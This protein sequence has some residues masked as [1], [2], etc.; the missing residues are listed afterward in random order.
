MYCSVI[1]NRLRYFMTTSKEKITNIELM[2]KFL[3]QISVLAVLFIIMPQSHAMSLPDPY[4]ITTI[5]HVEKPQ[6][7]GQ[8]IKIKKV[9]VM[10]TIP[11]TDRKGDFITD[12]SKNPFDINP[13]ILEQKVEFDIKTGKYVV[14][15]K[16]GDEYY[17]TPTYLTFEEYLDYKSKEQEREYFK[18]LA[19]IQSRKK[20]NNTGKFN[21]MS[22]IDVQKSLVDRLF[23]GTEINVKPQ[24]GIDLTFGFF[25]YYK[26]TGVLA[27]GGRTSPWNPIDP[28]DLKPR[29]TVDGNV[30]SKLK[31]NFNYDAQS[32]FNFDQQ[33]KLKY[34]SEAGGLNEDDIIKKIE[35]GNVS[36]PLKGNLIQGAQSL[37]GVKTDLQFGHLRMTLLASQQ[38][39][40]QNNTKI[41]NG[42]SVQ[43]FELKPDDYDEN[44]HFFLSHF[45]RA[46]Y[47]E[48]LSNIPFIKSSFK[49]AQ[50]QVWISDDRPDYQIGQSNIAAI[51]DL[52]EGD[53][54]KFGNKS[55]SMFYTPTSPMPPYLV[56]KIGVVL[57]DNKTNSIYKSLI[58]SDTTSKLENVT[59]VL[60][61]K[62][63][64]NQTTDF[65]TF[66][67]RLLNPSEYTYNPQLGYIS[68]NLRLR[69]D[70]RLGVAYK[71]FYT[72]NC[73][74]I[75]TV[76]Q[77]SG[78]ALQTSERSTSP[79][80]QGERDTIKSEKVI[81]VKLLKPSNQKVSLP[82]WDLM[83]K[84]VYRLSTSSLNKEGFTFDI[85][86]KND[87]G[88]GEP[89]KYIPE[90]RSTPLLN[91]FNLDNLNRFGDPQADG[92]F[93]YVQGI[94]VNEKT[95]SIIFPVLEPFGSSLSNLLNDPVLIERY[96]YQKL[97]DTTVTTARQFGQAQNKF[98][99]KGRVKSSTSG[100]INLGPFVPRNGVKVTAGGIALVEGVDYEIDYSLGKLRVLNPAYLSQGTPINVSYEDQSAFS[101][102][103][104]SMVGIRLDYDFSKKFTMGATYLRLWERPFTQK[105]NLGDDPINNRIFGIDMSYSDKTPWV[106]NMID[107]L[108]FYSTKAESSV[109]FSAEAAYLKP[110][111]VKAINSE[112]KNQDEG[113]IVYIDDFEGSLSGLSLGGFNT[114]AWT[115]SSTPPE[116]RESE[117][118]NNYAYGAN[119]AK[120]SW[121][122]IDQS[123]NNNSSISEPIRRVDQAHPYSRLVTQTELFNRQVQTGVNQL[124]TFDL[125]F[126]PEL[127]GPY[128]FDKPNGYPGYS[129]GT[130][131]D[132]A[133]Q[134]IRLLNPKT[135]WGG[136]MRY[137]QNTDF[138]ANNYQFI[139]FWVLNPFLGPDGQPKPG[140]EEGEMVF[141]LGNVSEDVLRDNLQFYENGLPSKTVDSDL[142]QSK[143]G[144]IP[145]KIPLV[146]GFVLDEIGGQDLGFD[147]MN[148]AQERDRYKEFLN[149]YASLPNLFN[150]PA[151]DNFMFYND[152]SL[153]NQNM[154]TRMQNFSGP[155]GNTPKQQDFNNN[156]FY[157]GSKNPDTE[158]LNNNKALEQNENY[159]EY[160]I[161]IKNNNGELDT[162]SSQYYR[163]FKQVKANEK[164]YR[165]VVPLT[166]PTAQTGIQGFR[167][168]QFM[169]MYLTKFEEQKTFRM[170]EFQ[171]VR[172]QW[173][174]SPFKTC[175]DGIPVSSIDEVGI[176]ENFTRKPIGYRLVKGVKQQVLSSSLGSNLRQNEKSIVLNFCNLQPGCEV[177]I[178]KLAGVKL[179]LY[180]RLQMFTHLEPRDANTIKD[181]D[182][183][184]FIKLGK[185]LENNYYEYS[186]PLK[187]T[188]FGK[189]DEDI[190]NTWP[191][192]NKINALFSRFIDTK[193]L[194][195]A[196][197]AKMTTFQD[198]DNV[199]ALF[200]I[201][202][203]PSLGDV[204]IIEIGIRNI[205]TESRAL[206]G[207]AWFNELRTTGINEEGAVAAQAKAQAKIAD[208]G[209]INAAASYSSIGFGTLDNRLLERSR[210]ATTQFDASTSLGLGKLLPKFL[211]INLPFFAQYTTSK[212]LPQFD[213]YQEDISTAELVSVS[214]AEQHAEIRDRAAETTTIKSYNVTNIRKE[215]GKG[216]KP[217][218]IENL[219][220]SY[221]YTNTKKTDPIIREDVIVERKSQLD[222]GYAG[223]PNYIQPLKFIKPKAL[224]ILSEFNFN[225]LPTSF[226]FNTNLERYEGYKLFR[227]PTLP[228]YRFDDR[229]YKWERNYTLDWDFTKALRMNFKANVTSVV[230]ELRQ[231]GIADDPTMRD[232]VNEKDT[233]IGRGSDGF[234]VNQ[235]KADAYR[236]ANLKK[237][238]RAKIYSHNLTINYKLPISLL[239]L[240]DWVSSSAEYR[241]TYGWT[242]GPLIFIDNIAQTNGDQGNRPGNII[243]NTQ[244]RSLNGT[245]AFDKLYSK[246]N[247][248]KKI[249]NGGP[250][251]SKSKKDDDKSGD[252]SNN[253]SNSSKSKNSKDELSM[254]GGGRDRSTKGNDGDLQRSPENNSQ[255]PD[256]GLAGAINENRK[257]N[258]SDEKSGENDKDASDNKNDKTAKGKKDKTKNKE[259]DR[260]PSMVERVLIRPLLSVRNVKFNYKEE[261]GTLL[262]GFMP[263]SSLLG[264]SD[265]FTSPG[266]QFAA[267]LQPDLDRNNDK[268][269]LRTNKTWFNPSE[270]FNDQITQSARQNIN[271][272]IA[273]EPFKDFKIDVDF[274]KDHKNNHTEIFKKK[275]SDY[276]QI[277]ALDA[278]SFETT[279]STLN[280]LFDNSQDV[281]AQFKVN[282]LLVAKS[283]AGPL[284]PSHPDY[285]N[286]PKGY[287]PV[288]YNVAVPAFLSAYSGTDPNTIAKDVS[289]NI[290]AYNYLPKP[291]WQLRYDGLSKLPMFKDIF[292]SFSLK[293][294]YKSI[295]SVANFN[296]GVDYQDG[297]PFKVD[298]SRNYYSRI[299]IPALSMKEDFSPLI[300]IDLKTKSNMEIKFEYKKGRQ[301]DLRTQNNE[302]LETLNSSYVFGYGYV[303][304]NFKGFGEGGGAA[305]KKKKQT[306]KKKDEFDLSDRTD[307]LDKEEDDTKDPKNNDP[308]N[309]KGKNAKGK[310]AKDKNVKSDKKLT[311]NCDFS[312]RDEI[313]QRYDLGDE[314]NKARPNRGQKSIQI[315]PTVEYQ[316]YKN[317]ALRLYFEYNSTSPYAPGSYKNTN[318]S[319][320]V[321]VRYLFN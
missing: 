225:P 270:A 51:A 298:D 296:S 91:L 133:K 290:K 24:G 273:L 187:V 175:G 222:Y 253:K 245:F 129:F 275:G 293:H 320:G 21:P 167:S 190:E 321:I 278:G 30:G 2:N 211:P 152:S 281:I 292:T 208:L 250:K 255:N 8:N 104:K 148:D 279:Y 210:F 162:T 38:L 311:I 201:K 236:K 54:T 116:F 305:A 145:V 218:S 188:Q 46:N 185:D 182:L 71:Y 143:W 5:N 265:G 74:S 310:K 196:A 150:D 33:I 206:C 131:I 179:N 34:D 39:S 78:Q 121:Y 98:V 37:M 264:L 31:L 282:R 106:T 83:M 307:G 243:Q 112:I 63:G 277:T 137:F 158:D 25:T 318:M 169:R 123:V 60:R 154:I 61:Y 301:L 77:L 12:K 90:R 242:A 191:D 205:S 134:D 22:R 122:Q 315:N 56:S 197:G 193:K 178:N 68:L 45:N 47:E 299:E 257:N 4:E 173:R 214:P 170:A 268:N 192:T 40:K 10:D 107:K 176:E 267:G 59:T 110:G 11:M 135:R 198:P 219:S 239:P 203:T 132:D 237:L 19:G 147:G 165:F 240:M 313:S 114:S 146:N 291:N 283:L 109:A 213:P 317:L 303:I 64:M 172:N 241:S 57:P 48:A 252:K 13:N 69:P 183:A 285:P 28:I 138:E 157:R 300:G 44:R 180:K 80:A 140:N 43:D 309:A 49:I 194:K 124:F 221:S 246:W 297:N 235:A 254:G 168:I 228:V 55:A 130:R 284:S 312:L 159:Y 144:N 166:S 70:Q 6:S 234:A 314:S 108:P 276:M 232:W 155:Q 233:I 229:R 117:L 271:V 35:A 160:R 86:Y 32:T 231:V 171:L 119:R 142:R 163:Q 93:D 87:F 29:L 1:K 280:T 81:F 82:T 67:G 58:D 209:D 128:N 139:E 259:K 95:G 226:G 76:G 26:S 287:G 66:R 249:E 36:L 149:D 84:N 195:I 286:Y 220:G 204:K 23:G 304:N 105:V 181:G 14:Y 3:Y 16:I 42:A 256:A 102:L 294:G 65:E 7:Y 266:W 215:G 18:N 52:A 251:S 100:E 118:A 230:D 174:A 202:G 269:Y 17:R 316:M 136:I 189:S 274:N 115:L 260:A 289:G 113:G 41:E 50:I 302:L 261:F 20:S 9:I 96:S 15:E 184:V 199:G 85:F 161:K 53:V 186:M 319:S 103:N 224:K 111:H 258:A 216:G 177:A 308:K 89:L 120:L 72:D 101:S 263:N 288:N 238:G 73:D 248:L 127:R 272:K 295:L 75:Y 207:T 79:N 88:G 153:L 99:M 151:G 92:V 212:K 62:Y 125:S 244:V 262:P 306:R 27:T 164:W 223:R 227:L 156:R 141:H 217:W 247:Y 97:Y 126:Y 200:S 94:T